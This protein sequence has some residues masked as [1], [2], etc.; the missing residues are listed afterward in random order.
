MS[1]FNFISQGQSTLLNTLTTC[2]LGVGPNFISTPG[3]LLQSLAAGG[4]VTLPKIN[5]VGPSAPGT[6]GTTPGC[7]DGMPFTVFSLTAFPTTIAAASGDTLYAGVPTVI[8]GTGSSLQL[9]ASASQSAWYPVSPVGLVGPTIRTV[10]GAATLAASDRFLIITT[11][12]ATIS[13]LAP[14]NYQVGQIY[15]IDNTTGGSLTL[16]PASGNIQGVAAYTLTT[17]NVANVFTDGSNFF[18]G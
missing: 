4:T 17:L 7:G 1:V 18:L 6:P 9:V 12:A 8:N 2:T 13:I 3:V 10:S 11:T 14:A 16:A 5:Q 15:G